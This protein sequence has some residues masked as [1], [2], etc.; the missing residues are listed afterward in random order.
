LRGGRRGASRRPRQRP[1]PA[2]RARDRG[3]ARLAMIRAALALLAVL[4][5]GACGRA[6]TWPA[7]SPAL[8]QVDGPKG[9]RAW[10]FGTIHAL[11]D[12][13]HWR[14]AALEKVLGQADTLVVEVANLADRDAGTQA[15]SRVAASPNLPPLLQRLPAGQRPALAAALSRA[16]LKEA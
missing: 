7:P 14:T 4:C 3:S 9:E 5:L 12:G 10:L 13:A 8:W 6:E 1:G 11:P 16:G 2:P 15:F